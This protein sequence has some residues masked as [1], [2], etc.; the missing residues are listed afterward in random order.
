[1]K[2]R[3]RNG[4]F[5]VR[6]IIGM[7]AAMLLSSCATE[8][9]RLTG[10]GGAAG[11]ALGAGLGA[12]VG[13][14]AGDPTTGLIM[15]GAAGSV[16]G[17]AAGNVFDAEEAELAQKSTVVRNRDREISRGREQIAALR[18]RDAA[19]DFDRYDDYPVAPRRSSRDSMRR[20]SLAQQTPERR[21]PS[22]S[23]L[24]LDTEDVRPIYVERRAGGW[25]REESSSEQG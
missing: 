17:A 15:G 23:I 2:V 3:V 18:T 14:Q 21:A 6:L 11:G 20:D 25:R 16:A 1:M 9:G 4:R 12:L 13:S 22:P 8:P 10:L 19:S 24:P 7:G 5:Q